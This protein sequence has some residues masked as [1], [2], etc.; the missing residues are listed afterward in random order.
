MRLSFFCS[1]ISAFLESIES[2]VQLRCTFK[3][4]CVM[5]KFCLALQYIRMYLKCP[6]YEL[7]I[8]NVIREPKSERAIFK[9]TLWP[10]MVADQGIVFSKIVT[11]LNIIIKVEPTQDIANLE[12]STSPKS[13]PLCG[14]N[15]VHFVTK[16]GGNPQIGEA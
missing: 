1:I 4:L 16:L 5:H 13:C 8:L 7:Q 3:D 12:C 10:N 9:S 15:L 14:Q 2:P 6:L 11:I